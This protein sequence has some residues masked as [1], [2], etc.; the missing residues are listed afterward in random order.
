MVEEIKENWTHVLI[1]GQSKT[2]E[3]KDAEFDKGKLVSLSDIRPF[4]KKDSE[5]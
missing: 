5:G 2:L 3:V 4:N 1:N